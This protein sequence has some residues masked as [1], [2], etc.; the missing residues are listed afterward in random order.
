M[1]SGTNL[2]CCRH[3]LLP[4]QAYEGVNNSCYIPSD[5][6]NATNEGGGQRYGLPEATLCAHLLHGLT[7]HLDG[8]TTP[9]PGLAF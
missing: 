2:Y 9:A 5:A 3:D 4:L 7:M 1:P 6:I 8:A